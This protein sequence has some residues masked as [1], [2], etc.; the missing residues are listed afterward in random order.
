M[1][2]LRSRS[3]GDADQRG[4]PRSRRE[5]EGVGGVIYWV[6]AS[7]GQRRPARDNR[8]QNNARTAPNPASGAGPVGPEG[9]AGTMQAQQPRWR[10]GGP[11]GVRGSV[12]RVGDR[13]GASSQPR[14][15][16]PP[17]RP[18]E[19]WRSWLARG[20]LSGI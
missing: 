11:E 16:C 19:K 5:G 8:T 4:V 13:P 3:G 2:D 12:V 14:Q 1:A 6:V 9:L 15:P 20:G 7:P 18:R 10:P 17:V